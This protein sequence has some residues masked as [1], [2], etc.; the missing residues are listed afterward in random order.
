MF[1]EF[2]RVTVAAILLGA[3]VWIV[4][5]PGVLVRDEDGA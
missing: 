5:D 1:E 3:L 4:I 2:C